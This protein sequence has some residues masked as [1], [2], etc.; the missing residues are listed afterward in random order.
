MFVSSGFDALGNQ[1]DWGT[2]DT[3]VGEITIDGNAV[4]Q[5]LWDD[6][7]FAGAGAAE[8]NNALVSLP[9]SSFLKFNSV[10]IRNS[11]G[12][13]IFAEGSTNFSI[14]N[15]NII[16]GAETERYDFSTVLLS[17]SENTKVNACLLYT[18]PSPRD[19]RQ[20]RMPSSA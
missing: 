17:D 5:I 2:T 10:K 11:S 14:E 12:A 20:S 1:E 19:K 16:N 4:N 13:A 15:C 7:G 18:S 3:T 9:N 8:A 6:S